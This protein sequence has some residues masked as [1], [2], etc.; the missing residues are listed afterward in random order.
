MP[1]DDEIAEAGCKD[2]AEYIA[3]LRLED[4]EAYQA[5]IADQS[6]NNCP[7]A[8]KD[9]RQPHDRCV[10]HVCSIIVRKLEEDCGCKAGSG[11]VAGGVEFPALEANAWAKRQKAM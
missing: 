8:N 7:F 2:A 9:P 6:A 11:P 5:M 3:K 1:T 10:A 4:E